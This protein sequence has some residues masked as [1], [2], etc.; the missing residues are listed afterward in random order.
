MAPKCRQSRSLALRTV[1]LTILSATACAEDKL[2]SF[3]P[4]VS[5]P[6]VVAPA[7]EQPDVKDPKVVVPSRVDVFQQRDAKVDILWVVD[8]SGSMA[9]ERARL[10][11]NFVRFIS[12]LV[13]SS[14]DY[15]IG[16]T[17]TDLATY[18][19]RLVGDPRIL[20]PG[21]ANAET[22][23]A[24]NVNFP[25]SLAPEESLEAARQ[26]LIEPNRSG[27]NAGF[28]RRE[29]ALA[30]ILLTDE[31]DESVGTVSF[32]KRAFLGIKGAGNR[33]LVTVSAIAGDV[34]GGCVAANEEGVYGA[35][36][37]AA[38]RIKE[39][40]DATGGVFGS[41]CGDDFGPTIDRIGFSIA[42]L[43]RVFP[44]SEVPVIDTI[45]V[46]VDGETIP[47]DPVHGYSYWPDA[48]SIAF[49]G[50]FIP[51]ARSEITVSYEVQ[52]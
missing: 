45:A 41:I 9:D 23:F 42:G 48:N 15:Q 13:A 47:E 11:A 12:A 27:A 33:R 29:A 26:A 1:A 36:A 22:L 37:R 28:A 49:E 18:G 51:P 50:E 38:Q 25:A 3:A 46:G 31:D 20:T 30:V 5:K 2:I 16:V 7:V 6:D 17:A 43:I 34:P 21:I 40:V 32:Y 14:V 39:V 8:V 19:G 24:A 35:G 52:Q 10:A 44:L 4:T